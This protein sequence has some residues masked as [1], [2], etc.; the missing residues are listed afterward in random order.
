M[1]IR[2]EI[3]SL[4]NLSPQDRN[5]FLAAKGR[6]GN[7]DT[8]ELKSTV[9]RFLEFLLHRRGF[10]RGKEFVFIPLWRGIKGPFKNH[11]GFIAAE[12]RIEDGLVPVFEPR[13]SS[14]LE[15]L[16]HRRSL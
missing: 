7:S 3:Y 14:F 4:R 8:H 12:R 5:H 15:F 9:A 13:I 6:L 1:R 2:R 11:H 10:V 16:L